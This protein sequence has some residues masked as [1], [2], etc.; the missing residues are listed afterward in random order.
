MNVDEL[1]ELAERLVGFASESIPGRRNDAE[2]AAMTA[3]AAAATAQ[4][5]MMA[6]MTATGENVTTGETIRWLRVDTGN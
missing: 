5:M 4:A 2:L 6:Q 3:Q 1:L